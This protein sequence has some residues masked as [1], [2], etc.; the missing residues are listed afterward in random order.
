MV[1]LDVDHVFSMKISDVERAQNERVL[2]I[3]AEPPQYPGV[4]RCRACEARLPS[5]RALTKHLKTHDTEKR[6]KAP[7]VPVTN[8]EISRGFQGFRSPKL[9]VAAAAAEDDAQ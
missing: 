7:V 9:V 6:I 5:Y 1:S 8:P 4:F 2:Q 3:L